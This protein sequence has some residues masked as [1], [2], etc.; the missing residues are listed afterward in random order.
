MDAQGYEGRICGIGGGDRERA[1]MLGFDCLAVWV[2]R[3]I[4][5]RLDDREVPQ[6]ECLSWCESSLRRNAKI[7]GV[8]EE[9]GC[10]GQL[11]TMPRTRG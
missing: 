6:S 3:L 11:G 8:A 10:A 7:A 9:R 5:V 4:G 2:M 1:D